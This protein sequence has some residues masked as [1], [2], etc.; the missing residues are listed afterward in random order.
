MVS[1]CWFKKKKV[2]VLKLEAR[3][4]SSSVKNLLVLLLG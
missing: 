4:I 3:D 1:E 2:K